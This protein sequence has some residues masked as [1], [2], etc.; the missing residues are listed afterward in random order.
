MLV[1]L[2]MLN[3]KYTENRILPGLTT[4]AEATLTSE[5]RAKTAF[6]YI[7]FEGFCRMALTKAKQ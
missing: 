5:R 3:S 7:L 2:D 1:A 4:K 6:M